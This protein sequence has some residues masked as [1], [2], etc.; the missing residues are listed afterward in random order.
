MSMG[1]ATRL[2]EVTIFGG[3]L[4]FLIPNDWEETVEDDHY[5]YSRP[6]AKSGWFHV[7]LQSAR[8]VGESPAQMLKRKFD[9]RKNV[10]HNEQTGNCV[11]T[12]ERDSEE[13]GV[14]IHLYYWIVAHALEPDLL[15]EAVFSYTVL[16]DR[17]ND[18]QTIEMVALLGQIVDRANFSP[19]L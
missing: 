11:C 6:G 10:A 3:K 4:S 14:K 17:A 7:S 2:D 5:S 18:Q 12:Y 15:R 9:G 19:R 16:S 13:E 8:V 1:E